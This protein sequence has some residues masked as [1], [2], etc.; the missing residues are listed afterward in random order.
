MRISIYAFLTS[1]MMLLIFVLS[2]QSGTKSEHTSL[3]LLN[4]RF[5]VLMMRVFPNITERGPELNIRK[6]AHIAEYAALSIP[7]FLLF[8]ELVSS[9][10]IVLSES[11]CLL[12]GYFYA[13]TDEIHQAYIPGRSCSFT[14]TLIDLGG[15]VIGLLPVV[16]IC[17]LRKEPEWQKESPQ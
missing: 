4:T 15:T 13:C 10:S 2:S 6:Y 3:W 17:I 12:F 5:G 16:M 14:D 8:R 9:K 11:L 1:A 7:S